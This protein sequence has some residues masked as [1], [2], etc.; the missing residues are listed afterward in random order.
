MFHVL[1]PIIRGSPPPSPPRPAPPPHTS[2]PLLL[3]FPLLQW[4]KQQQG[5][6]SVVGG[7][8]YPLHGA[9]CP[10]PPVPFLPFAASS[11]VFAPTTYCQAWLQLHSLLGHMGCAWFDSYLAAQQCPRAGGVTAAVAWLDRGQSDR[12][13]VSQEGTELELEL[14]LMVSSGRVVGD[15]GPNP[16]LI[17]KSKMSGFPPC[18]IFEY[19][20]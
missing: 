15:S 5:S 20:R 3:L 1:N 12:V 14:R 6:W 17:L 10:L 19:I 9:F 4:R 13:L 18:W 2:W 16:R 7:I 8:P 11:P